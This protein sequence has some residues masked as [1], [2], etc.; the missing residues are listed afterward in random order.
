MFGVDLEST[1]MLVGWVR[2][3]IEP[4]STEL[5]R[6]PDNEPVGSIDTPSSDYAYMTGRHLGI[7]AQ[8]RRLR[9][10]PKTWYAVNVKE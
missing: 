9:I 5:D 1:Q 6:W 10:D 4:S 8:N 3:E 2:R 7:E